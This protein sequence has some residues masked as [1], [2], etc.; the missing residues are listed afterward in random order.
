MLAMFVGRMIRDKH[1]AMLVYLDAYIGSPDRLSMWAHCCRQSAPGCNTNAVAKSFHNIFQLY[2][3]TK[4]CTRADVA[5]Q[6]ITDV[7]H[8]YFLKDQNVKSHRQEYVSKL[9]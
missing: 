5:L 7:E 4:H 1:T 3:G 6:C 8:H 9:M 2:L